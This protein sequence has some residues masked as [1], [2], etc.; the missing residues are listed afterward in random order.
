VAAA[1]LPWARGAG[2]SRRDLPALVIKPFPV[3]TFTDLLGTSRYIVLIFRYQFP[4]P[5]VEFS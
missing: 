3:R 1:A 4:I 2:L 5:F